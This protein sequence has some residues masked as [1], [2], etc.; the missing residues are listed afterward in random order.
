MIVYRFL[1]EKELNKILNGDIEN[2][3]RKFIRSK[4]NTHRYNP[5]KKYIHFFRTKDGINEIQM[6]RK[7]DEDKKYICEFDIPMLILMLGRGFGFYSSHGYDDDH[8]RQEEFRVST[9]VFKTKWLKNYTLVEKTN[10]S[11]NMAVSD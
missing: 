11:S 5:N 7:F 8:T 1:G 10:E 6:L 3:G 2:L 4:C 9:D